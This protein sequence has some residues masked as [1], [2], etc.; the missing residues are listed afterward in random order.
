MPYGSL[1]E[2]VSFERFLER[3]QRLAHP[4]PPGGVGP[5]VSTGPPNSSRPRK[6]TS[7]D[8]YDRGCVS[9]A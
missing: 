5:P 3:R 2:V 6:G 7:H 8:D 1:A 9:G 4:V